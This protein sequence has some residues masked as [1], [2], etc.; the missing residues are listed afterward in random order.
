MVRRYRSDGTAKGLGFQVNTVGFTSLTR[1]AVAIDSAGNFFIVWDGDPNDYLNDDVYARR[2]HYTGISISEQLLVNSYPAGA[3]SRPAARL[4]DD[5]HLVVV[6]QSF[7]QDGGGW[8]IFGQRFDA[9]GEP[10]GEEFRVDARGD[11]FQVNTYVVNDQMY[12]AMAMRQSGEFVVA[13]QS[14]EQDGSDYGVFGEI[15][16]IV[17][18]GDFTG[19]GFIDF[20]DYCVLAEEWLDDLNPLSTDLVDDNKIDERDLDAFCG[21]WLSACYDCND[22][23][24]YADGKIDFRDYA[25]LTGNWLNQGPF[26]A[27]VTGDGIVDWADL[28]A[29]TVHWARF[30]E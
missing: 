19:D 12:P 23:D 20:R 29:L 16:P 17:P 6:W 25:L 1:P 8:G 5:G 4:N 10:L 21:Q 18:C 27:D 13:W 3:Q 28:K 30:C 7:S 26:G 24:I 15:G 9:G 11:E 14:Y 22:V 2:Y